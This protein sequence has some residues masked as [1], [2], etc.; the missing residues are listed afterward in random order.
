VA[1]ILCIDDDWF[2]RDVLRQVICRLR[3]TSKTV[4]VLAISGAATS[5]STAGLQTARPVGANGIAIKLGPLDQILDTINRMFGSLADWSAWS[6][7]WSA[8]DSNLR[9]AD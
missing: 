8:K 5:D 2:C 7:C 1:L 3:E 6:Y 4:P 9:R